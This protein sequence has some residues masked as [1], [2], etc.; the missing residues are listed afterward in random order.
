MDEEITVNGSDSDMT[1]HGTVYSKLGNVKINGSGGTVTLDQIV[2]DTF[3]IS[4]GGGTINANLEREFVPD[5][6][7]A[8][9]VE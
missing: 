4:G 9:L 1:V 2:A 8:G 6:T 7:I 5:L 3:Y